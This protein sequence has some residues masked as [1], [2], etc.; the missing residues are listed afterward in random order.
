MWTQENISETAKEQKAKECMRKETKP[1]K[2]HALSQF[3]FTW[4][5]VKGIADVHLWI[6]Y[7]FIRTHDWLQQYVK[8]VI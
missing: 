7:F 4:T 8:L 6:P 2:Y 1:I 5:G 3:S